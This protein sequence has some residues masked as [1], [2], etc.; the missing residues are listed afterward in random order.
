[1]SDNDD[2][3][4]LFGVNYQKVVNSNISGIVQEMPLK[5]S[6]YNSR[7]AESIYIRIKAGIKF[8]QR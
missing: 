1:M 4:Y 3:A 2:P 5:V 8:F 7:K 6:K